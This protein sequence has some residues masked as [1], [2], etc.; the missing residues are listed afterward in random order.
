MKLQN[1]M[2]T[3]FMGRF[4]PQNTQIL[5]HAFDARRIQVHSKK[6]YSFFLETAL[7]GK[8]VS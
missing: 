7:G 4:E 6:D 8:Y 1:C 3:M 2:P 5:R